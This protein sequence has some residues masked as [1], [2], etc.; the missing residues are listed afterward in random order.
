MAGSST[1][2]AMRSPNRKRSLN[3]VHVSVVARDGQLGHEGGHDRHG[4][5]A[6]GQLEELV[7][8]GPRRH[9]AAPRGAEGERDDHE[10]GDLVDHHVAERP[11]REARDLADRRVAHVEAP[12]HR[13]ARPHDGRPQHQR[14]RRDAGGRPEPEQEHEAGV[15]LDPGD[16]RV[17]PHDPGRGQQHADQQH[18]VEHRSERGGREAAVRVEQGRAQRHQAVEQHLGGEQAQQQGGQLLLLGRRRGRPGVGDQPVE[19]HDAAVPSG[20][21]RP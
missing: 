7:G 19:V 1:S 16:A 10:Q 5:H 8:V 14:H 9:A 12:P 4:E 6:V 11:A 20:W 21:R 2:T 15:G 3:R 18:V 13:D 17:V